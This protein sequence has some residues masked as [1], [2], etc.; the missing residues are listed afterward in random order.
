MRLSSGNFVG[1]GQSNDPFGSA[2]SAGWATA[3]EPGGVL[4]TEF[5]GGG[6]RFDPGAEE[7][8]AI[9]ALPDGQLLIVS[10]GLGSAAPTIAGTSSNGDTDSSFHGDGTPLA[11]PIRFSHF[12]NGNPAAL[13]AD[14]SGH[15]VYVGG[16]LNGSA[17]GA[18][19]HV[20][21]GGAIDATFAG[22]G[23]FD[24]GSAATDVTALAVQADGNLVIAGGPTYVARL[25][26]AGVL[27]PAFGSGGLASLGGTTFGLILAVA[28]QS[29]GKI[30]V[31][32]ST[33][34]GEMAVVRLLAD[35]TPDPIYGT[36][37]TAFISSF[38]LSELRIAPDGDAIGIGI[39]IA[40]E[41]LSAGLF[42]L[43]Q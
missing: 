5:D 28:I 14:G 18:V 11:L 42:R 21:A 2:A 16:G 3:V 9:V 25:S 38:S 30:L 27:D 33:N 10:V 15:G 23:A 17:G 41:P 35:G 26:P 24:V 34:N 36:A 19:L 31:A 20:T 22:S 7:S 13:A 39:D 6:H 1:V 12:L 37:G 32:G 8:S 43:A 29:D 4:D 40:G